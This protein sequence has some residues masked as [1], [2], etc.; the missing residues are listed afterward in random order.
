MNQALLRRQ[1]INSMRPELRDQLDDRM[2]AV[3]DARVRS[4][5]YSE[6]KGLRLCAL[7]HVRTGVR[8][9]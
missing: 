3:D 6:M 7:L 4:V 2:G 8:L 9:S 1:G 5:V